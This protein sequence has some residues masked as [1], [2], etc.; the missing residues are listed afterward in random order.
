MFREL[1]QQRGQPELVLF[2]FIF[3]VRGEPSSGYHA[4]DED[5]RRRFSSKHKA[6]VSDPLAQSSLWFIATGSATS[7]DTH[8]ESMLTPL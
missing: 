7:D 2:L 8:S 6:K 5:A 1:C 3:D 4:A